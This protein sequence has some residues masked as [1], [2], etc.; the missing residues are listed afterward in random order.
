VKRTLVLGLTA[1]LVCLGAAQAFAAAPP[2]VHWG[3]QTIPKPTPSAYSTLASVAC[4]SNDWCISVGATFTSPTL[5]TQNPI[6]ELRKGTAWQLV[7]VPKPA[8][9]SYGALSSVSCLSISNCYAVGAYSNGPVN[10]PLIEHWNGSAWSVLPTGIPASRSIALTLIKCTSATSCL[11]LGNE[12]VGNAAAPPLVD[13]LYGTRWNG[14]QWAPTS[15]KGSP[16]GASRA[17]LTSMSC[18]SATACFAMGFA[19]LNGEYLPVVERYANG[20][21]SEIALPVPAGRR[22]AI[23]T[24]VSCSSATSCLAVGQLGPTGDSQGVFA[25]SWNGQRWKAAAAPPKIGSANS[26][27]ALSCRTATSCVGVGDTLANPYQSPP[28]SLRLAGGAWLKLPISLPKGS[29][30]ASL[31]AIVCRPSGPCVAVGNAGTQNGPTTAL[32]EILR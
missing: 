1:V 10:H 23:W 2:A 24:A 29:V 18:A 8:G 14:S 13:A 3:V 21:W 20:V 12:A 26:F 28:Y 6:S 25:A 16:Y 19:T 27:N 31:A 7:Q 15:L 4:P 17:G 9:A 5:E 32:A 30:G 22:V 11:A